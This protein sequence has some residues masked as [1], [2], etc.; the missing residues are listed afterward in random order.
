MQDL[1]QVKKEKRSWIFHLIS[2]HLISFDLFE[3]ATKQKQQLLYLSYL[4]FGLLYIHSALYSR[5]VSDILF[6]LFFPFSPLRM[7]T[8]QEDFKVQ[9]KR[10]DGV[11]QFELLQHGRMQDTKGADDVLF[12]SDAHVDGCCMA[13]EVGGL[14]ILE[15]SAKNSSSLIYK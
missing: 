3:P 15:I 2:S 5:A 8:L 12:A 13:R 11:F 9:F 1:Q 14:C 6:F 4:I 7:H 10:A